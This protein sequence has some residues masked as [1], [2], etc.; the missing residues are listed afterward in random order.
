MVTT[1]AGKT[2][3]GMSEER[4]V[5]AALWEQALFLTFDLLCMC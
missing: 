5:R 1:G 2:E 4:E 3:S